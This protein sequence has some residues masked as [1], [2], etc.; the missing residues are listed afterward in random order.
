MTTETT[1]AGTETRAAATTRGLIKD[2][3]ATRAE[4]RRTERLMVNTTIIKIETIKI[5]IKTLDAGDFCCLRNDSLWESV[6][7]MIPFVQLASY[8]S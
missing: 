7:Q 2:T 4:D 3:A 8:Y 5:N 6:A 1:E